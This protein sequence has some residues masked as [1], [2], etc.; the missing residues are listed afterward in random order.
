MLGGH[1][2]DD[3][4]RAI[5]SRGE[6]VAGGYGVWDAGAGKE[7]LVDPLLRNRLADFGLV[8]PQAHFMRGR[9]RALASQ[10]DGDPGAPRAT[11]D[12]G[13]LTHASLLIRA[14]SCRPRSNAVFRARQQAADVGTVL[15]DYEHRCHRHEY[16]CQRDIAVFVQK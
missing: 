8:S 4:L 16:E 5:E 2:A 1:Y 14:C 12:D 15:D 3:D 10:H 9:V 6:I 13:D 11:S 7:F